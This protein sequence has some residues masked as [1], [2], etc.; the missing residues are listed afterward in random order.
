MR[1]ANGP[2]L[3][4]LLICLSGCATFSNDGRP[5][6]S[7]EPAALSAEHKFST[8]ELDML[9]GQNDHREL[10]QSQVV[11]GQVLRLLTSREL[12][13]NHADEQV[14]SAEVIVGVVDGVDADTIR[15]REVMLM[16]GQSRD[17]S[18]EKPVLNQLFPN[19]VD[20]VR[21]TPVPGT[22]KLRRD[23]ILSAAELSLEQ[24]TAL[25]V[26]TLHADLQP[27]FPV[28]SE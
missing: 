22:L 14:R 20:G 27:A 12:K 23:E 16:S 25:S 7:G 13:R 11:R 3:L 26:T 18:T 1:V 21:V 9:F 5:A 10:T 4:L 2:R 24:I 17:Q 6:D 8:P 19:R 15:L 28:A